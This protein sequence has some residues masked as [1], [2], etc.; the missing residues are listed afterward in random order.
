MNVKI[1]LMTAIR[2]TI[3]ILLVILMFCRE[4]AIKSPAPDSV[5]ITPRTN[6][7]PKTR[8]AFQFRSF[9]SLPIRTLLFSKIE[10]MNNRK[11]IKIA[12]IDEE[13]WG[14]K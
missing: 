7:P 6:P 13:N 2:A 9:T 10:G 11:A 12:T 8:I 4:Y 14:N 3:I 1:I 5:R